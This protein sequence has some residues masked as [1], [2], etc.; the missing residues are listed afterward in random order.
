MPEPLN[1]DRARV[2]PRPAHHPDDRTAGPDRTRTALRI[3]RPDLVTGFD[4]ALPGARAA[5]LSRLL[6]AL[7]REPLLGITDRRHDA[8]TLRVVLRD[9]RHLRAPAAAA[10]PF[11]PSPD[12]LRAEIDGTGYDDPAVLLR[13]L[14]LPGDTRRLVAEIDNSVANLALARAAA[15]APHQRRGP[16]LRAHEG[17][18]DGPGRLEQ[19][20]TDGHPLHPCCR[21]RGGMSV[22]D[23]LSYAPEHAPVLRLRRLRV[24]ADRWYGNAPPVLLTHPWQTERIRAAYPFLVPD[25][26]STAVR[27]LMSLR[28]VA[29]T[30]GGEHVKTAVDAQLTSA[31]RTVSAAA[32]HNGPVLSA[33]LDTL[34][35]DLPTFR[36]LRERAAGAVV[37]DGQPH[38]S[39]SHLRREA[40]PTADRCW[41][42]S[43][44]ATAATRTPGCATSPPCCCRHCSPCCTGGSPWRPTARTPW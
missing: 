3:L 33:L 27:P 15:P 19:L 8:G 21:T 20:V 39:L 12:G 13:V 36:V 9:G 1:D 40:P 41:V 14:A 32:L 43:S 30:D 42:R 37:V 17:R 25:G 35:A 38:R 16:V 10:E 28:T 23:V 18:A 5:V 26:E 34:T 29:P 7:D 6:G 22:A 24:P 31:V 4:A 44:P 2:A 11:A